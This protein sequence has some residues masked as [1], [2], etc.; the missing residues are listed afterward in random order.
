M[1]FFSNS[2]VVLQELPDQL[3]KPEAILL[4]FI[5]LVVGTREPHITLRK[6]TYVLQNAERVV[7]YLGIFFF[8]GCLGWFF[9]KGFLSP[10]LTTLNYYLVLDHY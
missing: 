1:G 6:T 3:I 10:T 5:V 9:F 4:L 8:F 7:F 2:V